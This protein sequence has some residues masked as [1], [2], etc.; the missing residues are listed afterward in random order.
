MNEPDDAELDESMDSFEAAFTAR[1][2]DLPDITPLPLCLA[3]DGSNQDEPARRL[4]EILA[5]QLEVELHR[6]APPAGDTP[7]FQHIV[8]GARAAGCGLIVVPAP[9]AED[10]AELGAAS[11]GTNLDLLLSR[12][13][14]PLLVVRDPERDI[15]AT[16]R[17]VVL[18][19]SFVARDD[20]LAAA[21]AFRALA[22]HGR[23]HLLAVVDPAHPTP[24]T[25]DALELAEF[26]ESALAGLGQPEMAGLVAAVQ[27]H[28]AKQNVGCRVSVRVGDA[29]E[30]VAAFAND[31]ECLL[32]TTC[33]CDE[34]S[35]S[36]SQAHALI[37]QS[38]NPVLVL[39]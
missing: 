1:R 32:V 19:L 2:I 20:A 7:P 38:R 12:R 29:V 15:E 11:I 30:T 25:A 13:A 33:P 17:E 23:L 3:P 6:L 27:R 16:L 8:D 4:A 14:T 22:P 31:L 35:P 5:A 28:A 9:F 24:Q 26:G 10:F 36:L 34:G 37:R 18:P 21:W 39:D